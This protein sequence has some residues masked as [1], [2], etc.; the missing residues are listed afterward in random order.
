MQVA[1]TAHFAFVQGAM[2]ELA[3]ELDKLRELIESRS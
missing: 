3:T 1:L 2:L